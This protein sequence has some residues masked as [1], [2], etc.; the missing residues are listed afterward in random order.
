M[1]LHFFLFLVTIFV[2]G[3]GN[4]LAAVGVHLRYRRV[5]IRS[6]LSLHG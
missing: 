1:S 3:H 5:V 6:R 2:D 4:D